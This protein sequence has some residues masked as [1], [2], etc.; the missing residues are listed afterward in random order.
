M[1]TKSYDNKDHAYIHVAFSYAS[2]S[3]ASLPKGRWVFSF[4]Y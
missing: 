2:L 3:Y 4:L 1:E